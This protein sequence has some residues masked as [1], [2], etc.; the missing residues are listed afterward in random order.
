[1]D[2][3]LR[4]EKMEK[5]INKLTRKNSYFKTIADTISELNALTGKSYTTKNVL[6]TI[7][8]NLG[9]TNACIYFKIGNT[10]YFTDNQSGQTILSTID[11]PNVKTAFET[12][13]TSN[14][15]LEATNSE[16]K[17]NEVYTW[18]FPLQ[19]GKKVVGVL[20]I[21]RIKMSASEVEQLTSLLLNYLAIL[22]YN[23]ISNF[24]RH[25][26]AKEAL[27]QSNNLLTTFISLS[28]IYTY[29]K[30]VTST[31]SRVLYASEN[32]VKMIG[33]PGSQITGKTMNELFPPEFA[34]KITTDDWSVASNGKPIC[35]EEELNGRYYTTFKYP[36]LQGNKIL[37]AGYT[38]DLTERR[39]AEEALMASETNLL[40]ANAAKDKFF[41]II[42]HDLRSPFA[43][44]V[45]FSELMADE[46]SQFTTEEYL[47]YSKSLN[48][49]AQSTFNL[50][51][52]LLE[53]SRVQRDA[54]PFNLENIDVGKFFSEFDDS[55]VDLARKKS[56]KL[57]F[58]NTEGLH[59]QADQDML[60]S[61]IRNLI[62]N[63]I[64]FTKEGGNVRIEARNNELGE[65]LFSVSDSGIGMN[66]GHLDK[67]FRLDTKVNRQGTNGE[68]SSGLGL[69]LCKEFIE[70]HKGKIWAESE[71]EKGSTFYFTIPR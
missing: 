9:G 30:E 34:A 29:I 65:T 71:V 64:K 1:M 27:Q 36:I 58:A 15:L 32:F 47:Q 16:Q 55:I 7:M 63:A 31:E 24:N 23:E 20:K 8:K 14:I 61:I 69:I 41:S 57:E 49:T 60:K 40:E 48:K 39:K 33:I 25:K 38:I 46:Q 6:T 59:V 3:Q 10:C 4:N 37:L 2:E 50:L 68:A 42:S 11:D 53:W 5:R 13:K 70:K 17:G 19:S 35:I 26:Q 62:V 56:I 51:E 12:G 28:P 21:D 18:F 45:A 43:T 44:L 66:Q 52:N 54:I 22:L 67:I